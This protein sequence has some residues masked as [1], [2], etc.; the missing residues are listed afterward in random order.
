M[1]MCMFMIT[2]MNN[3]SG[4]WLKEWLIAIKLLLLSDFEFLFFF[5]LYAEVFVLLKLLDGE[6][7]SLF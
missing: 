4:F 5:R 7:F 6:G 2:I 1:Y 3:H